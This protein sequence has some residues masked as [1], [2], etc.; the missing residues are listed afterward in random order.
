MKINIKIIK[1]LI[2]VAISSTLMQAAPLPRIGDAIRQVQPPKEHTQEKNKPLVEIQGVKPTYKPA[3]IDD[4]SFKKVFVKQFSLEGN[5]HI[6]SEKLLSLLSSYKNKNLTFN[7][8][9]IIASIITK[10]YRSEGYIVARAYIPIQNMSDGVLEI[11]II[12][13]K[14]GEFKLSNKSQVKTFLIQSMLNHSKTEDVINNNSLERGL[15]LVNDIPGIVISNTVIRAGKTIGSSDFMIT[16]DKTKPYDAYVLLNNYGGRYTGEQQLIAGLNLYSPFNIGDKL[17]LVGFLSDENNLRNGSISYEF[18]IYKNGLRAEISYSKTFYSLAREFKSLN[19]QGNSKS[20]HV[21]ISYPLVKKRAENLNIFVKV[22]ESALSDE[23][24]ATSFKSDKNLRAYS[25]GFDFMKTNLS[26]FNLNQ[27][28]KTSMILSHGK[29]KFEDDSQRAIDKAGVNT[30]GEYSKIELFL[31]YNI[32]LNKRITLENSFKYQHALGGKNLDG[33]EDFSVA[34][35][36]GV[37]LYPNGEL[38]A[39]NGYLLKLEAKYKLENIKSLS[40]SAGLFYEVGKAYMQNP[41]ATFQ[42]RTLQDVGISY[43]ANYKNYFLNTQ[44]AWKV[45]SENIIS[46]EDQNYKF[47]LMLGWSY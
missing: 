20:Y 22:K 11:A 46:E 37:K 38:S 34:G 31:N 8:M 6:K 19:A 27:Y 10:E 1:N 45:D 41:I 7:E 44:I 12:E 5:V 39:E 47:L 28:L 3:L 24:K 17:S 36:Y 25:L 29:L 2:M 13:G 33:S 26:W 16:I 42:G 21:K 32:E 40:H 4:K 35:A 15:L 14:Y 9:Q 43:Y 23:I 18:P 30:E